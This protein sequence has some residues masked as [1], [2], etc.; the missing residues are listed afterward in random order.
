MIREWS[1]KQQLVRYIYRY[2]LLIHAASL[3][4][5]QRNIHSYRATGASQLARINRFPRSMRSRVA[6]QVVGRDLRPHW[7][8]SAPPTALYL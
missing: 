3:Q 6:L 4:A 8:T 2:F 1:R 5:R 7:A